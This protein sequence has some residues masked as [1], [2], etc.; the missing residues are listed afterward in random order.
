M[1]SIEQLNGVIDASYIDAVSV[2]E[3]ITED[4]YPEFSL[5]LSSSESILELAL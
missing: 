1:V 2:L 3:L 4:V 5:S